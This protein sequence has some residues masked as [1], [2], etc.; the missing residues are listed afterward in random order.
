MNRLIPLLALL[1]LAGCKTYDLGPEWA[2]LEKVVQSKTLSLG[3]STEKG[4]RTVGETVYVWNLS[5]FLD[6]GEPYV[7]AMLKHEQVHSQRQFAHENGVWGWI[8]EYLTSRGFRWLEEQLGFYEQIVYLRSHGIGIVVDS[9]AK[10]LSG[11][12]YG[13]MVS[14]EDAIEWLEQVLNGWWH[15]PE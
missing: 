7:T 1:C 14:K 15:P 9:W 8:G 4:A 2:P 10:N 11:I 3:V 6:R 12:G 5:D 13:F